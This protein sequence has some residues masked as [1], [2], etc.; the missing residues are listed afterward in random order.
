MVSFGNMMELIARW[1]A[2]SSLVAA[3]RCEM[4]IGHLVRGD[5]S[6]LSFKVT[7]IGAPKSSM[8]LL[9]GTIN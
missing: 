4:I 3:T 6:Q 9:K 2:P 5:G 8:G 7:V 1:I